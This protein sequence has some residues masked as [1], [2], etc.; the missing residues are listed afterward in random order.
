[1]IQFS[2]LDVNT[3]TSGNLAIYKFVW[4]TGAASAGTWES[5]AEGDDI[6]VAVITEF[7]E[8][9]MVLILYQDFGI[10]QILMYY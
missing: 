10:I 6:I 4:S 8:Y 2:L 1:M 3:L 5:P 7:M 9:M